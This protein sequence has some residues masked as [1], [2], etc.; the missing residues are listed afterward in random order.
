M[1]FNFNII[2]MMAVMLA[3]I[4]GCNKEDIA[5]QPEDGCPIDIFAIS[6]VSDTK[7]SAGEIFEDIQ[8]K[9]LPFKWASEGEELNLSEFISDA[10]SQ[11][12]GSSKFTPLGDKTASFSFTLTSK[13]T[14]GTYDYVAISPK[15]AARTTGTAAA[16]K[17]RA[18][19]ALAPTV[20]QKPLATSPDA[21]AIIMT[22]KDLGHKSQATGLSLAFIHQTS[23]SKMTVTNFPALAQEETVTEIKISAPS[24]KFLSGRLWYS[25]SDDTCVPYDGSMANYV[26]INPANLNVN[27]TSF[28]IWWSALPVT[29]SSG[30]KLEIEATTSKGNVLKAYS[31]LSKDLKLER[32]KLAAYSFN[33]QKYQDKTLSFD[34]T[35]LPTGWPTTLESG[36]TYK[37][38]EYSFTHY[39]FDNSTGA[40]KNRC[41][42][43]STS[44]FLT[45]NYGGFLSLPVIEGYALSQIIVRHSA[46]KSSSR[47]GGLAFSVKNFCDSVEYVTPGG[48]SSATWNVTPGSEVELKLMTSLKE[49]QYYLTCTAGGLGISSLE[50]LY[51]PSAGAD[52]A[53]SSDAF[54]VGNLNIWMPSVRTSKK[55]AGLA[56]AEREWEYARYNIR[57]IIKDGAYDILGVQEA[58]LRVRNDVKTDLSSLNK[59]EYQ[60]FLHKPAEASTSSSVGFIYNKN[61]F[62]LSDAKQFWLSDTPEVP[63]SV[64]PDEDTPRS[65]GCAVFTDKTT[66]KKYFI[67]VAHASL[68]D[69]A[70]ARDADRILK[71]IK[72]N[73]TQNLPVIL[74]G[75]L[76]ANW[77][78]PMYEKLSETMDDSRFSIELDD[79]ELRL[80]GT[81]N[82]S[83]GTIENLQKRPNRIDFIF[84]SGCSVYDYRVLRNKYKAGSTM[85]YPS[86]HCPPTVKCY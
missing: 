3:A 19:F 47:R 7:V 73:N 56:P 18:S 82:G 44:H 20:Q 12:V 22:A 32:G 58:T 10:R 79:A 14:A 77:S 11:D 46:S 85:Q 70:N 25:Y 86:D 33:W 51:S 59:Y 48:N 8:G 64:D 52:P 31:I 38:G 35:S 40:S 17:G 53:H 15:S 61:R 41:T 57:D 76:N 71:V 67:L 42:Y 65:F 9:H 62:S 23:Y 80:P 50:L 29:L 2:P 13:T 83:A 63:A 5:G 30:D 66:G 49:H 43:N 24:G 34:F 45:L 84:T 27:S 81:H 36:K 21:S 72:D 68:N 60:Y 78:M 54:T 26:L 4:I 6:S 69:D 74:V 75:D 55:E 28:D 1:N 39:G 37:F 16:K